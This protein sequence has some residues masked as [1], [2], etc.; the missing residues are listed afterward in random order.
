MGRK[1]G[2]RN[3]LFRSKKKRHNCDISERTKYRETHS[4][5][6]KKYEDFENQELRKMAMML[7]GNKCERCGIRDYRV[8]QIDH[9][10]GGGTIERRNIGPR[11]IY[12][13][14]LE[15]NG[16]GYQILCA[17]CNTIK[18]D[19]CQENKQR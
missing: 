10:Y 5:E 19:E 16:Y 9:V 18:R 15:S 4:R 7:L 11:G 1:H 6:F 14:I 8:L 13:K 17:N 2:R 12:I 3:K